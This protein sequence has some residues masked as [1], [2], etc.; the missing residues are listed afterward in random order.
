MTSQ[1]RHIAPIDA[2]CGMCGIVGVAARSR[3]TRPE[4]RNVYNSALLQG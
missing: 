3:P 1:M 4:L 2:I